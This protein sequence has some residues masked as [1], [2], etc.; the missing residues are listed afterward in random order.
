MSVNGDT[1]RSL[2]KGKEHFQ[3]MRIPEVQ[4]KTNINQL[5]YKVYAIIAEI[6]VFLSH[7]KGLGSKLAIS[8]VHLCATFHF[9]NVFLPFK[10]IVP[11]LFLL[12]F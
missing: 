2:K 11:Y 5:L 9:C 7:Q 3:T 8:C 6:K 4:I 10:H 1:Q 12:F